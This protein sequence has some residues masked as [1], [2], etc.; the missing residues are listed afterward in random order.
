L[1][2]EVRVAIKLVV[3][4]QEFVILSAAKN[5]C[6]PFSRLLAFFFMKA[7]L[8]QKNKQPGPPA[9]RRMLAILRMAVCPR[10]AQ[11]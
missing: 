6:I 7:V 5:L 2:S 8:N 3:A 9:I 4:P 1:R 10:R 11:S